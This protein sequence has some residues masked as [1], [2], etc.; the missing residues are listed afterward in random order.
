MIHVSLIINAMILCSDLSFTSS[1]KK[2]KRQV[3]NGVD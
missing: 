3:M 1:V 2:V